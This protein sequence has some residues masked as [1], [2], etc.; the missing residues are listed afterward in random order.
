MATRSWIS[1][2]VLVCA[3]AASRDA[4]CGDPVDSLIGTWGQPPKDGQPGVTGSYLALARGDG[5]A[6]TLSLSLNPESWHCS[7]DTR[8][9]WN[10]KAL[11]L[12]WPNR[13]P[14][15]ADKPCWMTA[16]PKDKQLDV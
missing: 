4:V 6:L 9:D 11:R 13:A 8:V 7:T 12:E 15:S 10:A 3:L 2:I 5:G 14:K 16:A 1:S